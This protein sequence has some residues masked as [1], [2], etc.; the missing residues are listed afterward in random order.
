VHRLHVQVYELVLLNDAHA[1]VVNEEESEGHF[2]TEG[3]KCSISA[4]VQSVVVARVASWA[5]GCYDELL[6]IIP[7]ERAL[8]VSGPDEMR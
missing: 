2:C 3:A 6:V 8:G 1:A 4:S 7:L 5:P